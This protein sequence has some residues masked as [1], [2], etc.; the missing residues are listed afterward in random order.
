M[1]CKNAV[2]WRYCLDHDYSWQ[3]GFQFEHNWA[4]EDRTGTVRLVLR[5]D[6]T[7]TVTR[8]Y[9]WDGCTPKFCLLDF[10][11]GIPDG[12]VNASTGKP[13]TYYASLIHDALYQFLPDDLPLTR[14]QA[15][16]CFLRLMARNDF[17]PR[18][19]YY[20]AVWVFGGLFRRGGRMIRKTRGRRVVHVAAGTAP[21]PGA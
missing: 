7:I 9:A 21:A 14:H 18:Y 13:K 6:G 19:V 1:F 10:S 3:S 4:F 16:H 8:G 17:A 20:G 2:R 12:V 11:F 5:T 15:D